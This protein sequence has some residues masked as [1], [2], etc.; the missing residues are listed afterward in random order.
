MEDQKSKMCV[1]QNISSN[2]S[3]QEDVD[4]WAA[5]GGERWGGYTPRINI[6]LSVESLGGPTQWLSSTTSDSFQTFCLLI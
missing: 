1:F 3:A 4:F 2:S 6:L 5:A